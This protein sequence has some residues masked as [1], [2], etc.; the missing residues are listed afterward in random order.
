MT[1]PG[2]LFLRLPNAPA[3]ANP[4]IDCKI[5]PMIIVFLGPILSQTNAPAERERERQ[6]WFSGDPVE[7]TREVLLTKRARDIE[8]VDQRAPSKRSVQII[9]VGHDFADKVRA[10]DR[11]RVSGGASEMGRELMKL[12]IKASACNARTHE[13]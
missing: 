11:R 9:G 12:P 10:V 13:M 2:R 7:P 1:R 4:K 6:G 8:G 5:S 3:R